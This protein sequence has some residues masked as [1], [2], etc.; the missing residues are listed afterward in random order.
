[1]NL[2]PLNP[3]NYQPKKGAKKS[4]AKSRSAVPVVTWIEPVT[5]RTQAD[6]DRARYLTNKGYA[7]L[8]ADELTEWNAGLKGCLNASDVSRIL[9]NI[10]VLRQVLELNLP[11]TNLEVPYTPIQDWW[12]Y[13]IRWRVETIRNSYSVYD[14]TPGVP[15]LDVSKYTY[16]EIN[17]IE[18]I[19]KDVHDIIES[20][21]YYLNID[22]I[23]MGDEVGLIL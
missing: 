11:V 3:Y 17:D 5:D 22:E 2:Q 9:N 6:V 18:Q 8:T 14:D 4:A 1:M 15:G 21:F 20:N 19:L 16:K 23:T 10:E 12:N 7:N 13:E